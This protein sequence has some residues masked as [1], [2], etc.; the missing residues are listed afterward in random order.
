MSEL[1][2][3]KII[4]FSGRAQ[5]GKTSC[6]NYILG[7]RMWMKGIVRGSFGINENG[8]LY[9]TDLLGNTEYEGVFNPYSGS[10]AMKGFLA[11]Y[12]DP[13]VKLYSMADILKQEVCINLLGLKWEQCYGTNAQKNE[14]THLRWEDF[15]GCVT[16]KD[17]KF[18]ADYSIDAD[19]KTEHP[20]VFYHKPGFMTGRE[21]MQFVG[22][23]IFRKMYGDCHAKATINRIKQDNS[24]WAIIMDIRFPNEVDV[25]KQEEGLVVRL[26]RNG[27]IKSQHKSETALDKN[28]YDWANFDAILTNDKLTLEEQNHE[29]VTLLTGFGWIVPDVE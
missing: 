2:Q 22:T 15:P 24:E 4:A 27:N 10:L 13:Y 29:V 14:L 19:M 23:E 28:N 9:V 26:T 3:Q 21:T 16:S 1:T 18:E 17:A 7:M 20:T 8:D 5:A 12:V 6:C 11:E 25:V